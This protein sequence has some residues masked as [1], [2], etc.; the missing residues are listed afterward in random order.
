[1]QVGDGAAQGWIAGDMYTQNFTQSTFQLEVACTA[2]GGN[3]ATPLSLTGVMLQTEVVP[4]GY[5][6]HLSA[7]CGVSLS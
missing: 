7:L 2:S 5:V 6:A 1:M 3:C 4:T